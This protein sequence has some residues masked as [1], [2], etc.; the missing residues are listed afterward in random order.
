MPVSSEIV[1]QRLEQRRHLELA[2]A[3]DAH[4]AHG[5]VGEERPA[6]A[7]AA[8]VARHMASNS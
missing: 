1:R 3:E 6:C 5:D 4:D 7:S 2:D 8:A